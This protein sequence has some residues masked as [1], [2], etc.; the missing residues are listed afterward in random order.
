MLSNYLSILKTPQ[1]KSTFGFGTLG[2]ISFGSA[3]VA[4]VLTISKLQNSFSI[5]GIAAGIFTFA[6]ALF[7]PRIGR[8]ADQLGARKVLLSIS[9]INLISFVNTLKICAGIC[10]I[11]AGAAAAGGSGGGGGAAIFQYENSITNQEKN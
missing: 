3:P 5:A 4:L 7:V 11:C 2:R 8:L 1:A 9:I 6:G 10:I